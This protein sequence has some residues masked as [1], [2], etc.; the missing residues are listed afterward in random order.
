V[1]RGEVSMNDAERIIQKERCH[2]IDV[3]IETLFLNE[4]KHRPDLFT[5][6]LELI[7]S[8]VPNTDVSASSI[9]R[10][11]RAL[12]I[13]LHVVKELC[14]G[15][16]MRIRTALQTATPEL[17]SFL[18]DVYVRYVGEWMQALGSTTPGSNDEEV[19]NE[20][21]QISLSCLKILRRLLVNGFEFVNRSDEAR[22]FWSVLNGQWSQF[23]NL[24]RFF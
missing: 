23:M 6:L 7:R 24:G 11:S 12:S 3:N 9:L 19:L 2:N 21:M 22:Q 1:E 14:S 13:L 5:T 8:A 16:V 17:F 20:R 4:K 18:A 10:L 15:R